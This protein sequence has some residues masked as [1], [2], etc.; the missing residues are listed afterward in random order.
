MNIGNY[1]DFL[2]QLSILLSRC[3]KAVNPERQS[4]LIKI[5]QLLVV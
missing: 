2:R 5:T 4:D 3:F 1:T